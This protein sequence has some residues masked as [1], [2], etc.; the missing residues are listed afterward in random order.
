MCRNKKRSN[1]VAG[2]CVVNDVSERAYQWSA[3]APLGQ[4]KGCDTFGPF[5]PYLVTPD[6]VVTPAPRHVVGRE[7][8]AH[9]DR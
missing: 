3:R 5:G 9:A 6:E 8:Q 1:H 7:R 2:Y 4:S